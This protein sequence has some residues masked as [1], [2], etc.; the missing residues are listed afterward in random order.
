[1][2]APR[3]SFRP[4]GVLATWALRL[5]GYDGV[6]PAVVLLT[7]VLLKLFFAKAGWVEFCAIALPVL[8][9]LWRAGI[10]LSLIGNNHCSPILRGTQRICLFV[11]L[12][13]LLLIDALVILS[14]NLPPM[15]FT[16]SDLLITAGM[17]FVYFILM[18]VATFPGAPK[19][20]SE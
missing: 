18:A 3:N 16:R 10:G 5:I 9:Y 20:G 4:R 1:M 12:I 7:P 11:G 17:F 2:S 15:A 19:E 6:L 14:V 8:A 13:L